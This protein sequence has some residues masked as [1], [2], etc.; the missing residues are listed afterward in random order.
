MRKTLVS[1][2]ALAALAAGG[3]AQAQPAGVGPGTPAGAPS[4]LTNPQ[5]GQ[6]GNVASIGGGNGGTGIG[7][8]MRSG[9]GPPTDGLDSNPYAEAPPSVRAAHGGRVN[10]SPRSST[11][12]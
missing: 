10:R 12:N 11:A 2:L 6:P 7:P 8:G 9:V 3:A 4:T 1:A 5:P